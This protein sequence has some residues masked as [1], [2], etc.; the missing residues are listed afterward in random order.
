MQL[1]ALSYSKQ[2]STTG[3]LWHTQPAACVW[4]CE[5]AREDGK[6]GSSTNFTQR[7]IAHTS[8]KE[9]HSALSSN[10]VYLVVHVIAKK[11]LVSSPAIYSDHCS[12]VGF[13]LRRRSSQSSNKDSMMMNIRHMTFEFFIYS[14]DSLFVTDYLM[15]MF[16]RRLKAVIVQSLHFYV[17]GFCHVL[18]HCWWTNLSMSWREGYI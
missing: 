17:L 3:G 7:N 15:P 5:C 14:F 9:K 2:I 18:Y 1:Y 10:S 6:G 12:H 8:V 16:E 4:G 11:A 13:I